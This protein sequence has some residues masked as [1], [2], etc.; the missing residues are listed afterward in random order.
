MPIHEGA[1][2]KLSEPLKAL[3]TGDTVEARQGRFEWHDVDKA[4]FVRFTQLAYTGDYTTAEHDVILDQSVVDASEQKVR[5]KG[6][7]TEKRPEQPLQGLCIVAPDRNG[8]IPPLPV[9]CGRCKRSNT[10]Q[11]HLP[12]GGQSCLSCLG[13]YVARWCVDCQSHYPLF[14]YGCSSWGNATKTA[15]CNLIDKFTTLPLDKHQS[16]A[17]PGLPFKPRRNA[18]ECEDYSQ[19]FLCHA[20]L[21]VLAH[22]YSVSELKKLAGHRLYATLKQFALYPSRRRDV[23]CV[24]R[25][26]FD[27]TVAGDEVRGMIAVY[28]ACVMEDMI[29]TEEMKD[30]M[31]GGPDFCFEVMSLMANRTMQS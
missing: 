8:A 28:F 19:V 17:G 12:R 6:R 3:L 5:S 27:N 23:I 22:R 2:S 21:Y 1:F 4:T 18:D 16:T 30:L 9:A 20:K 10:E 31:K 14:C 29:K 15:K 25:Y 13:K 11:H 7:P 24:A 26:I